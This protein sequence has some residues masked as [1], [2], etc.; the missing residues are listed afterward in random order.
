MERE[1]LL[2]KVNLRTVIDKARELDI[3]NVLTDAIFMDMRQRLGDA[4][5]ETT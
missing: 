4:F 2:S 3:D 5:E 1:E